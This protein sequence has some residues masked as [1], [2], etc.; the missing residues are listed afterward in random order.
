MN[1]WMKNIPGRGNSKMAQGIQGEK[2]GQ[3]DLEIKEQEGEWNEIRLEK[4]RDCLSY[5]SVRN[6]C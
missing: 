6:V 4:S 3:F 1:I 2:E 5:R